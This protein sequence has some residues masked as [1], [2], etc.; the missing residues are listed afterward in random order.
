TVQA[1]SVSL[2]WT[3]S[4]STDVA[5]YLVYRDGNPVLSVSTASSQADD[6]NVVNGVHHYQVRPVDLAGNVGEFSN[7]VS[8]TVAVEAPPSVAYVDVVANPLTGC[9]SL[10][11]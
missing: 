4:E 1:S 9:I 8:V 6:A 7:L 3:P 2:S 5:E 10:S 11:W